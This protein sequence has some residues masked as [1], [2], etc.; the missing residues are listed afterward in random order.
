MGAAIYL[1]GWAHAP[2]A[3]PGHTVVSN[4]VKWV[5]GNAQARPRRRISRSMRREGLASHEHELR[6][7]QHLLNPG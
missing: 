5:I 2:G 6:S 7:L 4:G 1:K 3:N